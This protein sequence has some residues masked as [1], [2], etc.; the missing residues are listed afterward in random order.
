MNGVIKRLVA[1][2][3]F[4]FIRNNMTGTEYFFHKDDFNGHWN[5]LVNDADEKSVE[6]PVNFDPI[7]DSPKGPRAANVRR[8]DYPNQ[9][10]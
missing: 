5:D 8:L 9:A 2:R 3:Q 1:N 4:G 7:K 10:V 6:I